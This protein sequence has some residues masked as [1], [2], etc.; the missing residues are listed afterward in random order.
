MSTKLFIAILKKK[1]QEFLGRSLPEV[2]TLLNDKFFQIKNRSNHPGG[3]MN[4]SFFK[5]SMTL[6][7]FI[8]PLTQTPSFRL[9]K[10]HSYT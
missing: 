2:V 1:N 10:I 8:A 9:F 5:N 6:C 3:A 4:D 7:F